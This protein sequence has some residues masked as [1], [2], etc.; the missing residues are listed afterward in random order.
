MNNTPKIL[1]YDLENAPILGYAWRTYDTRLL[2]VEQDTYLMSFA[3]KWYGQRGT[4]VR[5]LPDYDIYDE[6]PTN[7]LGLAQDLFDMID[8]AD[9]V[10]AHNGDQFD[11][12]KSHTA[13][14]KHNLGRPSPYRKVDT[15][16]ILRKNF[17]FTQNNLDAVCQQLGIGSKVKHQGFDLWKKCMEG[18][19]KAW[20][21][22]KK[23][24]KRDVVLLEGLY[25]RL[26]PYTSTVNYGLY[27]DGMICP[28]CGS[29]NLTKR[30]FY[31]TNTRKYQSYHCKDCNARP[32]DTRSLG[33][34]E[35]KI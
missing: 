26:K 11:D 2:S 24:N 5:A 21:T 3:A 16:K 8:Q 10:M 1:I 29:K 14:L 34:A 4:I 35:L 6:D 19:E 32:H 27:S 33:A 17:K 18:D 20:S 22:M 31:V 7:D 9:I 13:F 15:L 30:G 12:K 28:N 23:Y 25:D